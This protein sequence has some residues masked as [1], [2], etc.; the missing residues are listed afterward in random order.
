V[1]TTAPPPPANVNT[2]REASLS[3]AKLA[4]P[5]EP[6]LSFAA[7]RAQQKQSSLF[8]DLHARDADEDD[9]FGNPF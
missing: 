5:A 6:P 1:R 8:G 9:L 7:K 4:A 2:K 3:V